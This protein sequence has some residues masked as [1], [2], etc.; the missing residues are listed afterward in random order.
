[1]RQY[2]YNMHGNNIIIVDSETVII[3]GI[4]ILILI[5]LL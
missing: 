3:N 2:S 5:L 1:M 4:K